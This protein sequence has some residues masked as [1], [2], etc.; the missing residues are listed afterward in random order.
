MQ[1]KLAAEDA[2]ELPDVDKDNKTGQ[3]PEEEQQDQDIPDQ[4]EE[5]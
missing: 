1:G 4:E 5:V 3:Q 2:E